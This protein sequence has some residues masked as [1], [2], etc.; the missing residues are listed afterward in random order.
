M[1]EHYCVSEEVSF[2]ARVCDALFNIEDVE[3]LSG[4]GVDRPAGEK[5]ADGTDGGDCHGV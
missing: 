3:L 2:L 5:K 4:S 1:R